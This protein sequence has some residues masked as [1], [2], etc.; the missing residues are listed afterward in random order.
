MQ[1]EEVGPCRQTNP[2]NTVRP[3]TTTRSL[4]YC[5]TTTLRLGCLEGRFPWGGRWWS[6]RAAMFLSDA[7]SRVLNT[8][9]VQTSQG[10]RGDTR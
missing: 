7:T 8:A 3:L 9:G 10:G 5:R 2:P 1:A 4:R 6:S